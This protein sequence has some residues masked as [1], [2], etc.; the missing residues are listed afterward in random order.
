MRIITQDLLKIETGIICHAVNCF[1][2]WGA[3]LAKHLK[4]KYPKAF[5]E[6]EQVTNSSVAKRYYF[7]GTV[8]TT[9][10]DNVVIASLFTQYDTSVAHRKTEY[11]AVIHAIKQLAD[12][13]RQLNLPVYIPFKMCCGLGGGDWNIVYS[14]IE[15]FLPN[16]IICQE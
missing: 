1:G 7:L 13:E 3:G 15:A 9:A 5:A 16:A 11:C 12:I 8:K 6:Y 2:F 14:I 4:Y 10:V